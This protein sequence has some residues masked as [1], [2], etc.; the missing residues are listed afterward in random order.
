MI[1]YFLVGVAGEARKECYIG[2]RY[3]TN[4]CNSRHIGKIFLYI[5]H[6]HME[7][8]YNISLNN[9]LKVPY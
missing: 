8:L 5:D 4:P 1:L 9:M 6:N 2:G 7:Y 3:I